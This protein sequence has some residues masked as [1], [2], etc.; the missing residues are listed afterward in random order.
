MLIY[1]KKFSQKQ[2]KFFIASFKQI[3][4][5]YIFIVLYDLV[6]IAIFFLVIPL[7][8]KIF[9]SK[10][11]NV[12]TLEGAAS[13]LIMLLAYLATVTIILLL[14]YSVSRGLI[15]SMIL[16]KKFT[17]PFFKKF[18]L[19][20][21]LWWLILAL[22]FLIVLGAKQEY[23]FYFIAII[24]IIYIHLTSIMHYDFTKNQRIGKAMKNAFKLTYTNFK[25]FLLPYAYVTLVYFILLQV[26]WIVPQTEKYMF[27]ASVLFVVFFLAWFRLYLSQILKKITSV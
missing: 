2:F 15:W 8:S 7:F 19:L 18:L 13:V 23:L 11:Q 1:G 24:A 25:S 12:T 17:A 6:F 20:N 10:L 22:P 14:S 27:F 16:K 9:M 5:R 26:F 3:N 4:K 21:F